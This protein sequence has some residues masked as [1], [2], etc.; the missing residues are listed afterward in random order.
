M[1]KT[2]LIL[3]TILFF[4]RFQVKAA[5]VS[6]GL[7]NFLAITDAQVQD[8]DI[9]SSSGIGFALTKTAY[10]SAIVGVVSQNA[11]IT[12]DSGGEGRYPVVSQGT[13]LVRVT[14]QNGPIKKGDLIAASGLPGVGM[15][16][17]RSGF[18]LGKALEDFAQG[19]EGTVKVSLNIRYASFNRTVG[20]N[21]TDIFNLS[22][23]ATY[24]EPLTVFK[25]FIAA[26]IVFVSF[27]FGFLVFGRVA[28]KGVDALGRN[29]LARGVIQFGII[30]N[31]LITVAV[32]GAGF[33][34]AMVI[35]RM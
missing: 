22:S 24:E 5:E 8:G 33:G 30:I 4:A 9:V 31:V 32:V 34:I 3:T 18:T 28:G 19:D 17:S 35:L 11:A 14:G 12:F 16:A 27:G 26:L 1:K 25:Y 29:P 20:A 13:V 23:L 15:K 10:D 6:L 21:L 2:A 7:A